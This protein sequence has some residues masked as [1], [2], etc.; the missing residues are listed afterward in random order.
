MYEE[1][2]TMTEHSGKNVFKLGFGL[3]RLPRKEDGTIDVELTSALTDKFIS[4]GGTYFD[5][6]YVYE[7]SEEAARKA[8]VERHPRDSYTIASKMN[9]RAAKSEE[10]AKAQLDITMKRLGVDYMD[11][12]LLHALGS[13]SYEACTNY[14]LW[15]FIAE[16]KAQGVLRHIGFSFHD[17]PEMLDRILTEHPE[18]DFLQLQLNYADWENPDVQSR[19]CYETARKHGK[20]ITV[21]EPCKGGLLANPPK[22]VREMF[23]AADPE[24][25]YA[26]WA[27]RFIA[28]K[29]GILTVLSGMNAMDQMED[30]LSVVQNLKPMT[31]EEEQLIVKAQEAIASGASIPCTGCRYCVEGCPQQIPIPQIFKVRNNQ[32]LYEMPEER[33]KGE[34]GFATHRGGKASDCVHCLQCEEACP[35]HLPIT[36]LLE[37]LAALYE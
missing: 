20:Y 9:V 32:L 26:S 37:E 5:T 23:K 11:Y 22:A 21:M 4:G 16:K 29:E 19:A 13:G 35:Q 36:T 15:E 1:E 34:Y 27:F 14:H 18:V 24:A 8:L 31:A 2:K 25:S 6:A 17:T 30:N 33:A 3:M 12:Y 10:E 28:S 7:G